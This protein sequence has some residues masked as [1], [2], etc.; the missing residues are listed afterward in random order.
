V[1]RAAFRIGLLTRGSRLPAW[2][3]A[4]LRG[5]LAVDDVEL[6][7]VIDAG[8]VS[9]LASP[10]RGSAPALP[11]DPLRLLDTGPETRGVPRIAPDALADGAAPP[12]DLV[13]CVD[14]T[15]A[16][17][18]V[19]G[20]AS[21]GLWM[22]EVDDGDPSCVSAL[23]RATA[24][25]RA[26]LLRLG[27]ADDPMLLDEGH[28]RNEPFAPALTRARVL[29][30]CAVWPGRRLRAWRL[31]G[32]RA[33]EGERVRF[34]E[35]R[36]GLAFARAMLPLRQ[37]TSLA[38]RAVESCFTEHWAVGIVDRP[39]ASFLEQKNS[40]PYWLPSRRGHICHTDPFGLE[41]RNGVV[42]LAEAFDMRTG[43]GRIDALATA[44]G[45]IRATQDVLPE[46]GHLSYPYLVEHEGDVYCIPETHERNRISLYRADPFPTRWT[47]VTTLVEGFAGIDASVFRHEGRWWLLCGNHDDEC[48]GK[49]YGFYAESLTGPWHPHA[50]NPLKCDVRSARPAGT[51]FVHDGVLYRPAQDCSA[52]Y[53]GAVT[54]NRVVELSPVAFAEEPV[55]RVEPDRDGPYPDGVHTLAAAGR[56]TLLDGKRLKFAPGRLLAAGRYFLHRYEAY[57]RAAREAV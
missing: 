5:L 20:L 3:V 42:V 55:T 35:S 28:F 11:A 56:Q 51:P 16:M 46:S 39:I 23:A 24:T 4:A 1:T 38:A 45:E 19:A 25:V 26:R 36:Q 13:W 31:Q 33:L 57:R 37:A 40:Q 12:L 30:G 50:L 18:T 10:P 27:E 54:I 52:A 9:D 34:A 17:P 32:A 21:A 44:G 29:Y 8:L 41:T 2:Q 43:R 15:L 53:G 47:Y 7:L 14:R 22:L 49:L 6:A 48:D